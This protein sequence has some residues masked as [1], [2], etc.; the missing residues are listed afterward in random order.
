MS[1]TSKFQ[2]LCTTTKPQEPA[3]KQL[4]LELSFLQTHDHF[5]T[6]N[7]TDGTYLE[8]QLNERLSLWLHKSLR[9]YCLFIRFY[10]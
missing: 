2:P 3:C 6:A 5:I 9:H 10:Q 4:S 7:L 1:G 8:G